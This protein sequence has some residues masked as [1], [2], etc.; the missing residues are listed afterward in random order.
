W[1]MVVS[2]LLTSSLSARHIIGGVMTYDCLGGDEYEFTL[3]V[4]R[5]CNCTNCAELDPFAEIGIYRCNSAGDCDNQSQTFPFARLSAPLSESSFVDEPDYPCLIPPDVCGEEGIY[6]FRANLPQSNDS[7]WVSYQRCCR[8]VTINNIINP[9]DAGATFTVEVT[10]QAQNVCNSSPSF[11][12]YPPIII[13]DNSPIEY[14]HSAVDPD[15]DLLVYELCAPL[16]GGGPLLDQ[17]FYNTC[18]GANPIPACPPPYGTVLF[19]GPFYSPTAPMAGDPVV[20]INP[21]T[22]LITGTPELQGQ[23]VVGVCVSEFRNGQLL[24]RITRDFQ[25]NVA[26]CDPTVVADVEE[27]FQISDQ[28]FVINSCGSN[29]VEFVNQSFQ[30]SFIDNFAWSFDINGQT[31]IFSEWSPTVT[32]PN[33]GTYAGQ[34]VLNE[35][36]DCGDTATIFVNIYPD[37]TADFSYAYDTCVAGPVTFTDLSETGACCLTDWTWGFGDGNTSSAQNPEHTYQIPGELPVTLTVR[38]TNSCEATTTQV[39]NYFPAPSLIVIAPSAEIACEPEDIFFNNLSFPIDDTYDIFWDFGEGG[40]S[41]EISPT[42]TYEDPG[43]FTVSVDITSPIGCQTDTVFNDLITILA[44]P[45]AGFSYSP[46]EVSNLDMDVQFTDESQGAVNWRWDFGFPPGSVSPSPFVSFPDTGLFEV[47]QIVTHPS[48]CTDTAFALIDVV[49]EVRYFLPNAFTPNG[50]GTNDS[51]RGKGVLVGATDF[52]FM[53]WNRW[54]E[55]IFETNDPFASW[56]GQKN[57][58]GREQ[59]AGVYLVR[60]SYRDPRGQAVELKGYV[61]L[62]R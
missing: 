58:V 37:I 25:F 57:N 17:N 52:R 23:Y 22:G 16:L 62:I 15:G 31:E 43:V 35:N 2:C 10:P 12:T 8:N 59:P 26:N 56:N 41:S 39:I 50:D 51:F 44:S 45:E 18:E 20:T 21:A 30:E 40:S 27:D 60:V 48:G 34:L 3:R 33:V 19:Q 55:P 1:L 61:T 29:T 38:D 13:C 5:D 9:E 47:L 11:S 6:R 42:H 36:T 53:I 46:Q 14:D 32:F 28:Q 49:P 4:Y 24:S 7:Y 54:G